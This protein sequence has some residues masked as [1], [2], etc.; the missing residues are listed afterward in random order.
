M[1]TV[2]DFQSTCTAGSEGAH[3][4]MQHSTMVQHGAHATC[5]RG[6]S[7]FCAPLLV[8][9]SPLQTGDRPLQPEARAVA[10][11]LSATRPE[12]SANLHGGALVANYLLDACDGLVGHMHP[13]NL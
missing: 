10:S 7:S 1:K 2:Y 9:N 6:L 8:V 5:L 13:Y 3:T 11:Y 12:L 4:G